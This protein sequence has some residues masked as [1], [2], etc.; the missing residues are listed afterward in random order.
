MVRT[1]VDAIITMLST[2]LDAELSREEDGS[3]LFGLDE[4][5]GAMLHFSTGEEDGV[6][7]A[8]IVIGMPDSKDPLFYR[9][10]L[11]A[12]YMGTGTGG[13]VLSIDAGTGLLVLFR[14]FVLPIDPALFVDEFSYLVGSARDWN[15]RLANESSSSPMLEDGMLRA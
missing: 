7:I 3:V 8:S 11:E 14:E 15:R 5:M 10:M 6:L 4:D 1:N 12:N 9:D 13:G 2:A